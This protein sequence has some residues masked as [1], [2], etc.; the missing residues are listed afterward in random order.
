MIDLS[1]KLNLVQG[2]CLDVL[3]ELP[4]KCI[5]LVL[6]DPPYGITQNKWDTVF[7]LELFWNEVNRISKDKCPI[8]MTT[9]Q[10]FTSKIIMSNFNNFKC[11]W[12]WEK[13]QGT[14][15]LN[16]KMYPLKNH[17][18]IIVFCRNSPYYF[19]VMEKGKIRRVERSG[20]NSNTT[21]YGKHIEIKESRYNERYPKSVLNFNVEHGLHPTQKP[22]ALIEYLIRT[23][24]NKGDLVLD[25]FM[26]SGTTGVAS[27]KLGRRFIGIEMD[28][29]YFKIAKE[30]C[31]EWENQE[32]LF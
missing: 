29:Y 21:N 23:Y 8:V 2:D 6:T 3:K 32:R 30:R 17:E 31:K 14:G 7:D 15:H 28:K 18:S 27:L 4:D 20:V 19:P 12:I 25:C 9:S 11:E 1:K 5:D 16:C 24:S 22:I 10:P 26:G 13:P